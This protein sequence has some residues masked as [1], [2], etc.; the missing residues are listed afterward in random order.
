VWNP[1]QAIHGIAL[2]KSTESIGLT[3]TWWS[4]VDAADGSGQ[5]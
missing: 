3:L 1:A 4:L 2:L 5:I